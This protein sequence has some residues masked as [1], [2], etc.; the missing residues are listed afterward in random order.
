MEEARSAIRGHGSEGVAAHQFGEVLGVV[1]GAAADR[2]HFVE[3][4]RDAGSGNLP[5]CFGAR[6][7]S[8]DDVD[9]GLGGG[10]SSGH[11]KYGSEAGGEVE[12][13]NSVGA[14]GERM[15]E[16]WLGWILEA[17]IQPKRS[18]H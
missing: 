3:D 12:E 18:G 14:N 11:G 17:S 5:G 9:G 6:Q 15:F 16:P 7:A 10:V 2:A 1:G 4:D 8:A 13:G